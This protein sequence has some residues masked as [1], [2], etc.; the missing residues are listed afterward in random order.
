MDYVLGNTVGNDVSS[1]W[2]Q[3]PA[4]SGNQHGYAKSF[5]QFAPIGPILC[6][7]T[8]I[9]DLSK[10][11]LNTR[12]NGAERQ[13]TGTDDL[14]FDVPS[15]IKHL[16]RGMTLQKGSVI[17]TGTPGGVGA[18]MKPPEWLADGDIVAVEI[19]QIGTIQNL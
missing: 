5:D 19:S 4:Q 6:S 15:I 10:L 1:R 9:P 8:W 12:V 14:I 18:F 2:W 13:L 7:P 16:S 11:I 17:M 3:Q